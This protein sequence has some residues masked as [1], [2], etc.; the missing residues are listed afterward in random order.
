MWQGAVAQAFLPVVLALGYWSG[1][2]RQEYLSH[3]TLL[4]QAQKSRIDS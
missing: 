2:G 1:G 3:T 4:F